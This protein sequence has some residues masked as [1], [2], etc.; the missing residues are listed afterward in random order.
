MPVLRQLH[1]A[2]S[3]YHLSRAGTREL[4]TGFDIDELA[5][6]YNVALH[7]APV[8]VDDVN[9]AVSLGAP[10][11][12][13]HIDPSLV[14]KGAMPCFGR[15]L[16]ATSSQGADS[17]NLLLD[18][19]VTPE[20]A[21]WLDKGY[22]DDVSLSYYGENDPRNPTPG[23]KQ[24]RHIGFLGAENPAMKGMAAIPTASEFAESLATG[25]DEGFL[26][27]T[28]PI[29]FGEITDNMAK[30][31]T[32]TDSTTTAGGATSAAAS[33]DAADQ[34]A[35]QIETSNVD[36]VLLLVSLLQDGDKGYKGEVSSFDPE[37]TEDNKYLWND[38]KQTFSGSF[39]DNSGYEVE[40]YDFSLALQ[41]DGS[42]VRSYKLRQAAAN[43]PDDATV[44][45]EADATEAPE[46][47]EN[48]MAPLV[49]LGFG[50]ATQSTSASELYD[51]DTTSSAGDMDDAAPAI[52]PT[53]ITLAYKDYDALIAKAASADAYA[54]S[55]AEMQKQMRLSALSDALQPLYDMGLLGS[56]VP[57]DQL[58]DAL[59][60]MTQAGPIG[61]GGDMDDS[62]EYAE[63]EGSAVSGNAT[64][65]LTKF[66]SAISVGVAA[67]IS[68]EEV[69]IEFGEMPEASE[70]SHEFSEAVLKTANNTP[71][72]LTSNPDMQELHTKA[73]AYCEANGTNHR[74]QKD[75]RL[76]LK[77]V[78]EG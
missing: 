35:P 28:L 12:L 8:A 57:A 71:R 9:L 41:K 5:S 61:S 27:I 18:V 77:K 53:S 69:A 36:P 14:G 55:A 49:A 19:E 2:Y 32:G 75:Y 40:T 72:G 29:E 45:K 44:E 3:G 46:Y 50:G 48:N 30:K 42:L 11:V 26:S 1:A 73:V 78:T 60:A 20:F 51:G 76:A 68:K 64:E 15:V 31:L 16:S 23:H 47:A 54:A 24:I 4:L 33:S 25:I 38:A 52:A 66:L 34:P 56:F 70:Q 63:S 13:G 67:K 37:P 22:Y 7:K 59:D 65:V 74:N 58:A 17:R 43:D 21:E 62:Y 39:L 6:S 10:A